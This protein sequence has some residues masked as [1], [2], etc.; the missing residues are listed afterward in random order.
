MRLNKMTDSSLAKISSK[1]PFNTSY[2]LNHTKLEDKFF[3]ALY[4]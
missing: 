4:L 1:D 2:Y 3:S